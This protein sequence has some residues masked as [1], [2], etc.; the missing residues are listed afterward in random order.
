MKKLMIAASAALCATVGFSL[1]SANIVGYSTTALQAGFKAAGASFISI[2]KDGCNLSE[3]I[4]A[5]FDKSTGAV[6]IQLLN[7]AGVT[8]TT[9]KYYKGGRGTYATDGWYDGTTLITAE[10]DVTFAPGDGLWIY[11]ADGYSFQTSG[12]V[13]LSNV[14]R[15]LKTG[16][17]MF[18]NPFPMDLKLTNITPAGFDKSTG[19]VQIQLL[20]NAGVTTTTYKYYKGGRGTYATDGWYDGT[21]LITAEKD[22][23]FAPGDGLWVYGADGY[24]ITF[25][26][27]AASAE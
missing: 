27:G 22:V 11:G 10:K 13:K 26:V 7:N 4:P 24:T 9:Y 17:T 5:G 18:S 23:T 3:I 12:E 6:Q 25:S 20:N 14:T 1:E 16:F 15:N 19:A 2:G 8:T 21:T